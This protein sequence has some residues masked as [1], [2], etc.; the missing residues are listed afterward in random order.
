MAKDLINSVIPIEDRTVYIVAGIRR[1]W[2]IQPRRKHLN[3]GGNAPKLSTSTPVRVIASLAIISLTIPSLAFAQP[4]GPPDAGGT[5]KN[6]LVA[7]A[8]AMQFSVGPDFTINSFRGSTFTLKKHTSAGSA[9]RLGLTLDIEYSEL[10]QSYQLD[11]LL[12]Q[13]NDLQD[14]TR[15]FA[16]TFQ[17]I[18][19]HGDGQAPVHFYAA[20]GPTDGGSWAK[21]VSTYFASPNTTRR[22]SQRQTIWT[23]G[24]AAAIGVE[25][26]PHSSISLSAEYGSDLA[27]SSYS[28]RRKTEP[29]GDD[30]QY[31]TLTVEED[32]TRRIEL[33]PNSA[34]LGLSVYF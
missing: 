12:R 16:V 1:N 5:A 4:E 34:R 20:L 19:Y 23:V 26:F 6:S 7:G 9:Y 10:D 13:D 15:S 29:V 22:V 27:Y 17:K 18:F 3:Q 24:V 33:Q 25:W 8:W 14:G 21:S 31:V 30:G 2:I 11:T 28:M 32:K